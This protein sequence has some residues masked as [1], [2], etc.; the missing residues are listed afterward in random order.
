MKM[1]EEKNPELGPENP[2]ARELM[3]ALL[4]VTK[5][6]TDEVR[7]WEDDD[8][9]I[10]WAQGVGKDHQGLYAYSEMILKDEDHK[11]A[12]GNQT[13]LIQVRPCNPKGAE[14]N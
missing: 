6:C 13:Y 14:L 11:K 12:Y 1:S 7:S 3:S 8:D 2:A 10:Q 9:N 4:E 5:H